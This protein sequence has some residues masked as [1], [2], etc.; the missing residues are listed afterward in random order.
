MSLTGNSRGKLRIREICPGN[1]VMAVRGHKAVKNFNNGRSIIIETPCFS[2][3][4]KH[5]AILRLEAGKALAAVARD[6]GIPRCLIS[7]ET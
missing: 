7:E 3:A 5:A 4:F 2:P 1:N 6:T